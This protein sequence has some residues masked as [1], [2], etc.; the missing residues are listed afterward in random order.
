MI[1]KKQ[2]IVI[3]VCKEPAGRRAPNPYISQEAKARHDV[4]RLVFVAMNE[5]RHVYEGYVLVVSA[6]IRR[7]RRVISHHNVMHGSGKR[8]IS[9]RLYASTQRFRSVARYSYHR[10]AGQGVPQPL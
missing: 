9:H 3:Q 10:H 2:I 8:L 5:G 4:H 6:D 1:W 7:L